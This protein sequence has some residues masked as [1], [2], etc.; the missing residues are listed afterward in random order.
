[1][2]ADGD[3]T[4]A[5]KKISLVPIC[6]TVSCTRDIYSIYTKCHLLHWRS[7]LETHHHI[8]CTISFR[9]SSSLSVDPKSLSARLKCRKICTS[10]EKILFLK[11]K[12]TKDYLLEQN[13]ATIDYAL[14]LGLSLTG[15]G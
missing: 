10:F 9:R 7:L 15:G 14:A 3:T 2:R 5:P 11:T 1:M 6:V 12:P 4:K 8:S 13:A